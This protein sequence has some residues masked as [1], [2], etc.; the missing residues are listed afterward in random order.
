MPQTLLFTGFS[1]PVHIINSTPVADNRSAL[2]SPA[3]YIFCRFAIKPTCI[4]FGFN[5]Y[6]SNEGILAALAVF[7][8]SK[9]FL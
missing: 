1:A 7:F 2:S 8:W 3:S 6:A 5:R 9:L 4:E